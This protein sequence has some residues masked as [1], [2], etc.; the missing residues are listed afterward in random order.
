MENFLTRLGSNKGLVFWP[1]ILNYILIIAKIVFK[2]FCV[3]KDGQTF[4]HLFIYLFSYL[5]HLLISWSK[6]NLKLW[7][8]ISALILLYKI[9][10]AA[11]PMSISREMASTF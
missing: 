1:L 4:V 10:L 11:F 8:E 7:L 9:A 3:S 2:I 6:I 5:I